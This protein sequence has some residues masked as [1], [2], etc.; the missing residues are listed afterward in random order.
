VSFVGAVNLGVIRHR[1]A[2]ALPLLA[3]L[4]ATILAGFALAASHYGDAVLFLAAAAS[5]IF[6]AVTKQQTPH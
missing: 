1:C 4:M 5:M 2:I 6:I 3:C